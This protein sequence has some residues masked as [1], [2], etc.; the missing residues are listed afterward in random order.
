MPCT[1]K[2]P[3]EFDE[4]CTRQ[5]ITKVGRM[6]FRRPLEAEELRLHTASAAVATQ[7]LKSFYAGLS[8]ALASMLESPQFIFRQETVEPDPQHRG[9]FRLDA[10]SKASRLSFFLWNSMPDAQLLAAAENGELATSKGLARQVAR[11]ME[12][13]RMA[14]GMRAFFADMFHFD[15]MNT[16]T[17]DTA[18]YPKFNAQ[19]A[20]D[21]R[22]QTLKTVVDLLLTRRGDYRDLFTTKQTFLNQSLASI[23]R[24]PLD[25][26]V[27]NGSPD[28][29]VPY[30][31]APDDPRAGI[32]M[33]VSFVAMNSHPGRSSPTLRGKALREVMLCQKVPPPPGDVKFDIVQDTSNPVYK[34]ARER[35]TAHR[36]NPVCAG[37]HKLIDPMGLALENFDGGGTYRTH[38]NGAPIDTSG[39]L[40]GMKFTNGA[41]LG[42]VIHNAPAAT[43]CLVDRLSAYALGRTPG[44]GDASWVEALKAGFAA[45]GYVVPDLMRR[46]ALSPGFYAAEAPDT[47]TKTKL[48]T[49]LH[50]SS[51][52]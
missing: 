7:N 42:R 16:L 21:A 10:H 3:T 45:D 46:I 41:E 34:T 28:T 15:E 17:K 25:L 19:V 48:P 35:L 23:Y 4:A 12:S 5:F 6:L 11:M 37:C 20:D 14:A 43:S 9:G 13:P 22:E 8:F 36:T 29:W 31:F 27:P 2:S 1:P 32:L 49:A 44:P 39:E 40:D 52:S 26:N 33:Q 47:G 38:E 24:V 50:A 51:G 30:E 18:I